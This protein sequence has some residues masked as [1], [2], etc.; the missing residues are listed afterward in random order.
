MLKKQ[1]ITKFKRVKSFFQFLKNL[2]KN[3]ILVV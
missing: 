1:L 3:V 2:N